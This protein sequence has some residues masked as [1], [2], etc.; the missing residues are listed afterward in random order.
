MSSLEFDSEYRKKVAD[1]KNAAHT[2]ERR[3]NWTEGS[4]IILGIVTGVGV[5][6]FHR[7]INRDSIAYDAAFGLGLAVLFS[8]FFLARK[9]FPR[10]TTL[11]PECGHDWT[12]GCGYPH[13]LCIWSHCPGC[14]LQMRD[15]AGQECS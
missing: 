4:A 1:L 8:G 3:K 9:L 14:G 15:D 11:C 7:P 13:N 10:P 6:F 12:F 5:W 2:W